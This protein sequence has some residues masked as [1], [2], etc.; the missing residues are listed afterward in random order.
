MCFDT[1]SM[2]EHLHHQPDGLGKLLGFVLL[3]V[4]P[5]LGSCGTCCDVYCVF[6]LYMYIILP[7]NLW[8]QG[9][10]PRTPNHQNKS[11]AAKAN[12]K[13]IGPQAFAFK[14]SD[15]HTFVQ[16]ISM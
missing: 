6:L 5:G 10:L 9:G 7:G 1:F 4:G 16:K 13:L 8:W 2:L 11:S 3:M 12:V 14:T 15:V